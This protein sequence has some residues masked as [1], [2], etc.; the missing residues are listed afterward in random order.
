MLLDSVPLY[1]PNEEELK[2]TSLKALQT[3]LKD[4]NTAVIT[5]NIQ[6]SNARIARNEILYKPIS[7]LVDIAFDTKVYIKSVYGATSPQYKQISKLKFTNK[8][9]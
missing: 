7:G 6:L 8:K 4:T 2:I 1:A 9:D 3:T 5:T